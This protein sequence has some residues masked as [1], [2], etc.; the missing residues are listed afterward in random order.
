[1]ELTDDEKD[2]LKASAKVAKKL[3]KLE[4]LGQNGDKSSDEE[5]NDY[6]STESDMTSP[7]NSEPTSLTESMQLVDSVLSDTRIDRLDKI[8]RVEAILS[9]ATLIPSEMPEIFTEVGLS[10]CYCNCHS[11]KVSHD[12][13]PN[14]GST[15]IV[16]SGN[17]TEQGEYMSELLK[18][19]H[20]NVQ[21]QTL[22]TGDIVVTKI[23]FNEASD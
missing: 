23:Y 1:M 15:V 7:R 10:K 22:S 4:N 17:Y 11:V 21:T 20:K 13:G 12:R 5:D 6:P 3:E 16:P 14:V 8:E 2:K 19:N 18:D 9:A